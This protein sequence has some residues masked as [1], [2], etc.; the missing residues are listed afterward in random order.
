MKVFE[1]QA[2]QARSDLPDVPLFFDWPKPGGASAPE[3]VA[4]PAS[5]GGQGALRL[6]LNGMII[7]R[8]I[9]GWSAGGG[10]AIP[11]RFN[12]SFLGVWYSQYQAT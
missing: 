12:L 11:K 6:A 4:A 8:L 10:L 2:G 7:M 1:W 3:E 9:E 5:P